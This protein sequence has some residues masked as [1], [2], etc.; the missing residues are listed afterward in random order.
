MTDHRRADSLLMHYVDEDGSVGLRGHWEECDCVDPT[1]S[2]WPHNY[3]A[4]AAPAPD[5]GCTMKE[6]MSGHRIDCPVQNDVDP[7]APAP[8]SLRDMTEA[9]FCEAQ[10]VVAPAPDAL[11]ECRL[12]AARH[13]KEEWAQTILRFCAEGGAK[14]SPLR[15]APAPATVD[16]IM[17]LAPTEYMSDNERAALR[18]AVEQLV[19]ENFTLAA[20]QCI[21]DGGLVMGEYGNGVCT[22]KERAERAERERDDASMVATRFEE[23]NVRL[24]NERNKLR[25]LLVEVRPYVHRAYKKIYDLDGKELLTRIDAATKE[26]K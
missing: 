24:L 15:D 3:F 12:Y 11:E 19:R 7:A 2:R 23:E 6:R 1:A 17:A 16:E 18:A 22:M 4:H 13:R 10:G 14:G 9:D 20:G 5:C 25:A 8:K 21:V 26:G